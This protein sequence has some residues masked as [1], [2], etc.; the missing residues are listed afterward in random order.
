VHLVW[1]ALVIAGSLLVFKL[2]VIQVV[3]LGRVGEAFASTSNPLGAVGPAFQSGSIPRAAV[4]TFAISFLIGSLACITLPSILVPGSGIL[5]AGV[6]AVVGGLML[7]PVVQKLAVAMLPHSPALLLTGEGYIF[8]TIFGLLIPIYI[9]RSSLGGNPLTRFG[10]AL[11]LNLK[12]QFWIAL[13]LAVAAIYE[14][15]TVILM[16]H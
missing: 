15:M 14:A 5:L 12:A 11:L 9:V 2:P 3:L 16:N 4:V 7:A 8:A 1:F 6:L 10:R 13:V